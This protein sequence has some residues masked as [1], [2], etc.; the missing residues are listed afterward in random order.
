MKILNASLLW[1]CVGF[2]LTFKDFWRIFMFVNVG[3]CEI[4]LITSESTDYEF[5]AVIFIELLRF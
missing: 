2:F 5:S 3:V 4:V 1:S